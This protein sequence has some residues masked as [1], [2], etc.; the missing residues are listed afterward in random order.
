MGTDAKDHTTLGLLSSS[1]G[2]H[3]GLLP[4]R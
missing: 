3:W 1:D 4:A 2:A